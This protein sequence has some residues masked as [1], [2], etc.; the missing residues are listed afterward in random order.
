MKPKLSEKRAMDMDASFINTSATEDS[1]GGFN[2][3]QEVQPSN[4][5]EILP[6][7]DRNIASPL[8]SKNEN[9]TLSNKALSELY[10]NC[11]KLSAQGRINQNNTWNLNLIDHMNSLIE[12]ENK[13]T[14]FLK[15]SATID[16]GIQ[17]Y[18]SR[19]DSVHEETFRVLSSLAQ[20]R[21]EDISDSN[22]CDDNNDEPS[23]TRKKKRTTKNILTEAQLD[24]NA[25]DTLATDDPAEIFNAFGR[26]FDEETYASLMLY[27]KDFNVG[28][29]ASLELDYKNKGLATVVKGRQIEQLKMETDTRIEELAADLIDKNL[30]NTTIMNEDITRDLENAEFGNNDHD[31]ENDEQFDS[32]QTSINYDNVEMANKEINVNNNET[33]LQMTLQRVTLNIDDTEVQGKNDWAGTEHWK[34]KSKLSLKSITNITQAKSQT[35]A[36][37]KERT[38]KKNKDLIDFSVE[39]KDVEKTLMDSLGKKVPSIKYKQ[40]NFGIYELPEDLHLKPSNLQSLFTMEISTKPV[41]VGDPAETLGQSMMQNFSNVND[42]NSIYDYN[43]KNDQS[44][45]P[46]VTVYDSNREREGINID[47]DIVPKHLDVGSL[48]RKIWRSISTNEKETQFEDLIHSVKGTVDNKFKDDITPAYC[49]VCLLHLANENNLELEDTG[50]KDGSGIE[51]NNFTIKQQPPQDILQNN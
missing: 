18:S 48:K 34:Y 13:S 8:L 30:N 14:D 28:K 5:L 25:I 24:L 19:I 47:F 37:G 16:A 50:A 31:L 32:S 12:N 51:N 41:P 2:D 35:I 42:N 23:K 39:I 9:I 11:T 10:T 33:G 36:I 38:S 46:D 3:S 4:G 43:N 1:D 21:T 26:G 40:D 20:R 45:C 7:V 6:E 17:I 29:G 15:A 44:F 22:T 27:Q 49:F